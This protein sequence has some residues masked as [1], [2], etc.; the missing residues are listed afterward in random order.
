M[1]L[2]V[3]A[4]NWSGMTEYMTE[5]NSFP[6]RVER[7]VEVEEGPFKGHLW[8]EPSVGHLVELMQHVV[9]HGKEAKVKGKRAREDMVG[10]YAQ[11]V[12]A[13]VVGE[14]LVRIQGKLEARSSGK[15]SADIE[16]YKPV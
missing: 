13:R 5:G 16:R 14:E 10:K 11:E 7:M 15:S 4:T 1:E 12:V 8:A 6:L 9:A 3:I 2:P